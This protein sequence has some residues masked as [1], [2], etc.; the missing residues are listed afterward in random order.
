MTVSQD[1][2]GEGRTAKVLYLIVISATYNPKVP[3]P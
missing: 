3:A 1:D 2:K